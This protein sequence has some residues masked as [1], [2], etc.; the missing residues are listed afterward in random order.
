MSRWD[1]GEE[2]DLD[3]FVADIFVYVLIGATVILIITILATVA[4]AETVPFRL[5]IS[6]SNESQCPEPRHESLAKAKKFLSSQCGIDLKKRGK[7]LFIDDPFTQAEDVGEIIEY[8]KAQAPLTPGVINLALLPH[9]IMANKKWSF[10][11]GYVDSLYT[12]HPFAIVWGVGIEAVAVIV[13]HEI[14]HVLGANHTARCSIMH[15]NA[16]GCDRRWTVTR[17]TLRELGR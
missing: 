4:M 7:T 17:K 14:L 11:L 13:T 1:D 15:R 12:D 2:R 3:N 16:M 9:K 8:Y 10:G 6:N 5:L